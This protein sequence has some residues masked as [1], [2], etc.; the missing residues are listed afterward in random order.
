[1]LL[2]EN[3]DQFSLVYDSTPCGPLDT[4][5]CFCGEQVL[6]R[7]EDAASRLPR[8]HEVQPVL[9]DPN[10]IHAFRQ[11]ERRLFILNLPNVFALPD[12]LVFDSVRVFRSLLPQE[13]CFLLITAYHLSA[14][15]TKHRFCGICGGMPVPAPEER[16]LVCSQCGQVQYP[17]ISPAVIVAVTDGD[18]LLLARNAH[19]AFRHYSVIAGY[20]EVGETLEQTVAREVREEVG[21]SIADIR[22]I[23]SQPWALSQ[24]MMIGFHARL[25]GAPNITLQTSELAEAGWYRA[26]ELPEHAGVISIAYTLIDLFKQGK[27][28]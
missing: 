8:W 9:L 5:L 20:V 4:V 7:A 25:S 19:G 24:S 22:Y 10:P 13:D 16:A 28:R 6:L 15:Y 27:L 23:G 3:P 12:G 11:G 18:R 1:M 26:D 14:W 17:T 21:L 2:N